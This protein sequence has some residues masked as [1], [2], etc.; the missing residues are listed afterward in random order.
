MNRVKTSMQ[1]S[2]S[3]LMGAYPK[4]RQILN[5]QLDRGIASRFQQWVGNYED[6][7]DS[8]RYLLAKEL[9]DF[10]SNERRSVF[11]LLYSQYRQMASAILYVLY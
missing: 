11:D 7:R 9:T 8:E 5:H 3:L 1:C 10:E 2:R 6:S 4:S